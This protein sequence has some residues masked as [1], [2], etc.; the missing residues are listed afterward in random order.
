MWWSKPETRAS[1]SLTGL[2]LAGLQANAVGTTAAPVATLAAVSAAAGLWARAFASAT[3][4]PSNMATSALTPPILER[5][6]RSLL[7]RGESLFAIDVEGGGLTLTEAVSWDVAGG[8]EWVYRAD[9]AEPSGTVSRSL[10][11]DQVLHPRIGATP[12]RPFQGESPLPRA[13]AALA[14]VIESKLIEEV[15]GPVGA[16]VAQPLGG[17][18]LT[19]LQADI[20]KLRGRLVMVESTSGGYGDAASAPRTDWIPRRVGANPPPPLIELR[21]RASAGILA[22]AGCPLSLLSRSDGVLASRGA[23]KGSVLHV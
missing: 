21:E 9:F 16:V 8:R 13:T 1:D 18:S 3:V 12:G 15:G 4:T 23:A 20:Q 11:A 7:L 14:S 10:R 6:G 2:V 5:L 17:D 19:A 22:A